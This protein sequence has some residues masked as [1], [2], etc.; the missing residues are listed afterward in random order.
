MCRVRDEASGKRLEERTDV[1]RHCPHCGDPRLQRWGSSRGGMARLRCRGCHRTSCAST[2]TLVARV[3]HRS[4][5][6]QALADMCGSRPSS[7]RVLAARLGVH[8]MTIWRWR[9]QVFAGSRR[10]APGPYLID[11][12]ASC[13]ESR[14]ASR[15]WVNHERWPQAFPRPPRPRWHDLRSDEVPPGG[16]RAWRIPILLVAAA[17]DIS[18]LRLAAGQRGDFP[19]PPTPRED[20]SGVLSRLREFLAPFRG[21]A[22]RHLPSYLAWMETREMLATGAGCVMADA[23]EGWRRINQHAV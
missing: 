4:A 13:R 6:R 23:P 12:T 9:M 17:P 16:W 5:F 14:K 3:R 19:P 21:P 22:S 1:V 2:G 18:T 10:D 11:T 15:E 20:P 8:R 7:C